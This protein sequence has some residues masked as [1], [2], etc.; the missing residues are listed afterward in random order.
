MQP[1]T[2]VPTIKTEGGQPSSAHGP[3][4]PAVRGRPCP[5]D[6]REM[7]SMYLPGDAGEQGAQA[8]L[9][10]MQGQYAHSSSSEGAG[11]NNT[12]PLTHM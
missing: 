3:V 8:R 12:V 6:L 2:Q 9:Q 5:G 11:V 10:Q 4:N 1:P 7:I